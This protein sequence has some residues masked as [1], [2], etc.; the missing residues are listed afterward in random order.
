VT[1]ALSR[2]VFHILTAQVFGRPFVCKTVR[3]MLADL[4]C[5][6]CGV[7]LLWPNGRMDQDASWC[8]GRPRRR[9]HCVRW[10][11][12]PKGNIS[13]PTIQGPCLLW[14]NGRPSQL[15]LSS[16]SVFIVATMTD[17]FDCGSTCSIGFPV[18]VLP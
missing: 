3:P 4:S 2:L 10:G 14:P 5:P 1:M 17:G 6:V 13:P 15:L 18:S 12:S 8:G 11:A 7:C 16:C 9:P